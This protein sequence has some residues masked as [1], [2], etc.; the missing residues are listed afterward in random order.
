MACAFT[1]AAAASAVGAEEAPAEISFVAPWPG[2]LIVD[3]PIVIA[4]R[5]PGE[6]GDAFFLLNGR[7][8]EGFVRKGRTFSG[9]LVPPRGFNEIQVR[10]GEKRAL[11]SFHYGVRGAGRQPYAYHQPVIDGKCAACHREEKRIGTF[12]EA[13]VCYGC[14]TAKA[15]MFP[16][17]HGPVAAGR[18]LACHDPHGS[19]VAS[20]ALLQPDDLCTGCHDQPTTGE[21]ISSRSRICTLCHNPHY[22]TNK[23]FLKGA[24]AR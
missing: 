13:A 19:N 4:G 21:H 18:C 10:Y 2:S 7:P 3:G 9:S 16:Y 17:V 24:Y 6:D 1:L 15:I 14:H 11:L 5:L 22:G 20:L 12:T 8:A 23:K